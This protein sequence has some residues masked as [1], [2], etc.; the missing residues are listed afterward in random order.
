M[1]F[2][3]VHAPFSPRQVAAAVG[4]LDTR[5]CAGLDS[6]VTKIPALKETTPA[7]YATT[8]EAAVSYATLITTYMATFTLLQLLLEASDLG[9]EKADGPH[10]VQCS[11]VQ[12]SVQVL[13]LEGAT[14]LGALAEVRG[15]ICILAWPGLA[16]LGSQAAGN[17]AEDRH[18]QDTD[19]Q[20]VLMQPAIKS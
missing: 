8:K 17:T 18:R 14:L 3:L 20:D 6:L 15:L 11:A 10:S 19:R 1:L 12:C 9:L 4:H 2:M 7:L 16:F 5:F 13:A